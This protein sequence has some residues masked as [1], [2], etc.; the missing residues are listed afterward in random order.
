MLRVDPR[1]ALDVL[2]DQTSFPGVGNIIKC[3]SLWEAAIH[4][5]LTLGE[6]PPARLEQLV[7]LTRAFALRWVHAPPADRQRQRSAAPAA[8]HACMHACVSCVVPPLWAGA[9]GA[10]A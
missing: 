4:P 1:P 10:V 2:L 7:D 6:L 9:R 8:A 5:L 3:E